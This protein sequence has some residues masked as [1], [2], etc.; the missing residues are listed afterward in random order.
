LEIQP[1]AQEGE[2][3]CRRIPADTQAPIARILSFP[4]RSFPDYP[5]EGHETA[6]TKMGL[7]SVSALGVLCLV[8][9]FG[10]AAA[11]PIGAVRARR[12]GPM[13]LFPSTKKPRPQFSFGL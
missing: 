12:R 3:A 9:L 8:A 5:F 2:A 4:K 11:Q 1:H 10:C 7:R 13:R 6:E